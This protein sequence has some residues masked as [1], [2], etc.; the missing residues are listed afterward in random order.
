[1]RFERLRQLRWDQ[2]TNFMGARRVFSELLNGMDQEHQRAIGCK[3]VMIVTSA[4]Q[5]G[6]VWER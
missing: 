4:S 2:G 5:M 1:M 6:G 3:F